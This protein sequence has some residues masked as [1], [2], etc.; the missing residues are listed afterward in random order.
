[1]DLEGRSLASNS[2]LLRSLAL[3]RRTF[4]PG[5]R[6]VSGIR[7]T[8]LFHDAIICHPTDHGCSVSPSDI[9]ALA[10]PG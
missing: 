3:D 5:L 1:M 9:A 7:G 8:T 2:P 10:A 6:A 4:P